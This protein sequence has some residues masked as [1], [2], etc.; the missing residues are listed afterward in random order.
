MGFSIYRSGS[1][2]GIYELGGALI[3][4]CMTIIFTCM[5]LLGRC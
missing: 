1:W 3:S 2:P 4:R 5:R